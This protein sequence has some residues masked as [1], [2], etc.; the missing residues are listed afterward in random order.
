MK[1]HSYTQLIRAGIDENLA[2]GVPTGNYSR[3]SPGESFKEIPKLTHFQTE[4]LG[5]R[6]LCVI[7]K[8]APGGY[9]W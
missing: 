1:A 5:R 7:C 9:N 6:S 4:I 3:E 2:S 8:R